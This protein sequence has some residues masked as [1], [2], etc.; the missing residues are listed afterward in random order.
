M[1]A[2][3]CRVQ[4]R[5]DNFPRFPEFFIVKMVRAAIKR[6]VSRE[7]VSPLPPP[8]CTHAT[9]LLPFHFRAGFCSYLRSETR[10]GSG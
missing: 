7:G 9:P 1:I 4:F 8:S 5:P 2:T 10:P 6:T 3:S